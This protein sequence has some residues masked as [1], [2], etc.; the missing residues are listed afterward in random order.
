MDPRGGVGIVA[1]LALFLACASEGQDGGYSSSSGGGSGGGTSS[2]AQDG[3]TDS[4]GSSSG[5][6]SGSGSGSSSGGFDGGIADTG[7]A[8]ETSTCNQDAGGACDL[9]SPV[10]C[11]ASAECCYMG[12]QVMCNCQ[13]GTVTQG[14]SCGQTTGCAPGYVCAVAQGMTTGTCLAWCAYPCGACPGGTTCKMVF[15]PAPMVGGVTY[16]ACQ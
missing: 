15:A 14:G 1:G 5:S 10:A 2:G 13:T 4:T 3:G 8:V 16:G 9:T 11:A 6:G 7:S 12:G